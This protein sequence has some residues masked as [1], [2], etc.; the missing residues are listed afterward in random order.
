MD[1]IQRN[2]ER[3]IFSDYGSDREPL[4]PMSNWKWQRMYKIAR[5]YGIGGYIIDGL[6]RYE[7]DFFLK[8]PSAL[9]LQFMNL[10]AEK[11]QD[12]LDAYLLDVERSRGLRHRL[13]KR[14]LQVYARDLVRTVK[15][16]EE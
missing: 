3:L 1:I 13:S 12:K 4:E 14:S 15:N 11:R 6:R 2:I 5:D 10:P 8:M 16:I 9:Q 7:G